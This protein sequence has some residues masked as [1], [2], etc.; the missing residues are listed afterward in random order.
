[1]DYASVRNLTAMFF[2]QAKRLGDKPF[3]WEKQNGV[4]VSRSWR[5]V[6]EQ[7]RELARGLRALGIGRGDR[8]LLVSEN[9][10]EWLIADI[11]I[12]AA[13]GITVP[14]FTTN[15]CPDHQ[16]L[17]NN[18]G[19]KAVIVSSRNLLEKV[20]PAAWQVPQNPLIIVMEPLP[21]RQ[22]SGVTV[23][24]W[25]QAVA[26]GREAPDEIDRIIAETARDDTACLIYTSGTGGA[27]KG[28]MTH[29]GAIIHNCMGA[30]DVL[31]ELGLAD[32]VFLSFLP[33][34][35]SYE[36]TAGQFFP[37]SLGA[38]I[39]Y[40]EGADTLAANMLEARPTIMTAVPRL[41]EM[42]RLRILR[43]IERGD[44]RKRRFFMRALELGGKAYERQRMSLRE[45]LENWALDFLVRRKVKQRFGGR[46]KAMVSGGAPLNYEVGLFFTA[47]GVRILQGYGQTETGPVIAVNRPGKVKLH[48]VGP[49]MKEV[50]LR[51]APDGE[52]L[53]RGELVMQGYWGNPEAT[54]QTITDGRWLHT[55]DMGELD[56]DGHLVITDR[57][58][59]IIVNSGGDNISP[60]RI[61][62]F[63][64]LQPEIAQAMAYGDRRPHLVA[65][66]VPDAEWAQSWARQN[67]KPQELEQLI[68]DADFRRV[69]ANAVERVNT[70]LSPLEKIRRFT[71]IPE[72]FS[73][74]NEMMTPT[75]KIR[76]HIIRQHYGD[77]L[78]ALYNERR[79]RSRGG[80]E[81]AAAGE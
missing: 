74:A 8:V 31:C 3:L 51:I 20:L 39:Y 16:H 34:S 69:I 53:V 72:P 32:E 21:P 47:L 43:G 14:A 4:Y 80:E 57:K 18:S 45:R 41:Y 75:L 76:R 22:Q 65:L 35:H 19:A 33:L 37:I 78:E 59:D 11:A 38:Q 54:A 42:M 24:P 23:L 9:R 55:G 2:D 40:A 67:D 73:V 77:R 10:P 44:E 70:N 58:K 15:T 46:L 61:E 26:A 81:E 36:H 64:T 66:L 60:Q 63:L 29:H 49:P 52:I 48:A 13:G 6:A 30:Y 25:E 27:P 5:R 17:L 28:V 62:G 71:M 7:I 56:E 50:D 79:R 1:M 12:M 68:E